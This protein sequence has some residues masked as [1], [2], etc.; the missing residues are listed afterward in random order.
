[1]AHMSILILILHEFLLFWNYRDTRISMQCAFML[2]L[3]FSD[4]RISLTLELIWYLNFYDTLGAVA[5]LR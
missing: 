5:I 3:S 1:M 2:F 4:T